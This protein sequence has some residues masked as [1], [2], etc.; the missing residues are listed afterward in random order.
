MHFAHCFICLAHYG[1]HRSHGCHNGGLGTS[2]G[3]IEV[4]VVHVPHVALV[5]SWPVKGWGRQSVVVAAHDAGRLLVEETILGGVGIKGVAMEGV[6]QD[7]FF[8]A[9]RCESG[10]ARRV[11]WSGGRCWRGVIVHLSEFGRGR[12]VRSHFLVG[13][14]DL[15]EDRVWHGEE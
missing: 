12:V 7:W 9:G 5:H 13:I 4:F 3:L 2:R 8:V 15:P 10:S 14:S 11:R 6:L 1:N